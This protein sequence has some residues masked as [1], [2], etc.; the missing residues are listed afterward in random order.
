[1]KVNIVKLSQWRIPRSFVE[2]WMD[3]VAKELSKLTHHKCSKL[4]IT[5][6]FVTR[7]KIHKL[8]KQFRS[9]DKPTDILSF[10]G[11]SEEDLG[12]LVLCGDIVDKQAR[13]NGH[14]SR[15]ELGY[16]LI[17]GLL[18][19]L[20]YDHEKSRKQEKVMF[21]IQDEIFDI[22]RNRYFGDRG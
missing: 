9:K 10:E 21:A 8:N 17:H 2:Q 12:E 7:A 6:A 16:L 18:H 3:D 11:F 4:S 15:E 13:E 5:V 20:G 14:S 22:L 1:M 19:L